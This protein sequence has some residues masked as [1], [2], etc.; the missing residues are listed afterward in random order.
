MGTCGSGN[1]A[2]GLYRAFA[3]AIDARGLS[4]DLVSVGCF[5]FC[6]EEPLVNVWLPGHPLLMLRQVQ[7]DHVDAILTSLVDGTL[8]PADLILCRIE[9]WDHLT[10][11]VR[12]G[13][14]Y[15]EVPLW[16]EI[17]FFHGQVKIVLRNCGLINPDDIEEYIAVGGCQALYKVLIDQ[18][19]DA[20]VE[21][22]KAAR[23]RGRGGA[24]YLTGNKWEFLQKAPGP[25][26]YLI[27]NADEGDPGAYMNRNEIESDPHALLEGMLIAGFVTGAT[28]GIIYVRAEYPI[29]VLRLERAI[30]QARDYGVL[31]PDILGRGF[32]FDIQTVEGAG[33]FVCGEETALIASL[34][35]RA[36]AAT[37]TAAVPGP[38]GPIRQAHQTSTMWRPGATWPHHL[39]GRGWF[40]G[41]GAEKS[42]GT[43]VF[44]LAGKITR[45]GSGGNPHGDATQDDHRG[46]RRRHSQQAQV[47]GCTDRRPLRAAA[48]HRPCSTF[49]GLR[50]PRGRSGRSWARVEWW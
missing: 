12:Y 27:C 34:E 22:I 15:P 25:V 20:V 33:A 23:L 11:H 9:E 10:G 13:W 21:Q 1:G 40:A 4:V 26:K 28:N 47:Q 30:A 8:P 14:G 48:S 2:E 45:S 24:G 46:Y 49:R 29:A 42:K 6:A 39:Q 7:T 44:C 50:A 17:P 18:N 37:G 3:T 19:P 32:D 16:D 38:E 41:V 35:D 43:K 36:W 31:G 5:G